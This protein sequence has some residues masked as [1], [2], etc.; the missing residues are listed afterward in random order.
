GDASDAGA[1]RL[2]QRPVGLEC[3]RCRDYPE[4]YPGTEA[5]HERH[6]RLPPPRESRKLR[7]RPLEQ[8]PIVDRGARLRAELLADSPGDAPQPR[9]EDTVIVPP[10]RVPCDP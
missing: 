2:A 3:Q 9:F 7:I 8:R 6:R 10:A 5:R 1:A 4:H